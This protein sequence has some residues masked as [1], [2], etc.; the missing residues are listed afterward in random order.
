M[1]ALRKDRLVS[2][3][4]ARTILA[5]APTPSTKEADMNRNR[6]RLFAVAIV[7]AVL[8]GSSLAAT[9][10]VA[11]EFRV[12]VYRDR[13]AVAEMRFADATALEG[14]LRTRQADTRERGAAERDVRP[15]ANA[16]PPD[17]AYLETDGEGR[18]VIP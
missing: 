1:A 13:V 15:L 8:S 3:S 12:T 7:A 16:F 14:W 6:S 18:S 5:G 4:H 9:E 17:A 11:E 2:G 10:G